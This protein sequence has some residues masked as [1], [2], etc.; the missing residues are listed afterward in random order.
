MSSPAH[1]LGWIF[2][3]AALAGD[4]VMPLILGK[5]VPGYSQK[6]MVMS[7]LGQHGSPVRKLYNSWLILCG[8]LILYGSLQISSAYKNVPPAGP[9]ALGLMIYGVGACILAGIFPVGTKKRPETP[10]EKIH[11]AGAVTGFMILTVIPLLIGMLFLQTGSTAAGCIS[12]VC[13]VAAVVFFILFVMAD[14]ESFAGTRIA[15]EGLWQRLSMLCSYI[16]VILLSLFS[17][18]S[19]W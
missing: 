3:L 15:W 6:Y 4:L 18:M 8:I 17:L 11:A 10:S 1:I 5:F 2:L 14:K 7:L 16:P 13:F 12:I 19:A 9:A